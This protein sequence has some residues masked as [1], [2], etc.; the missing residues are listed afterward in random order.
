MP[1]PRHP[2]RHRIKVGSKKT[3]IGFPI[4]NKWGE[5]REIGR[6]EVGYYWQIRNKAGREV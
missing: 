3:T 6:K 5:R 1:M 2:Y 4:T